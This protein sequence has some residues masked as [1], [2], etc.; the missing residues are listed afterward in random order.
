M[1]DGSPRPGHRSDKILQL[2]DTENS[3]PT[4]AI[5]LLRTFYSFGF[6]LFI[7]ES[8]RGPS[9]CGLITVSGRVYRCCKTKFENIFLIV[10]QLL[11]CS[12]E[13]LIGVHKQA[14]RLCFDRCLPAESQ[15]DRPPRP[16][17]CVCVCFL[18]CRGLVR[19]NPKETNY[20]SQLVVIETAVVH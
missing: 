10:G 9:A 18:C 20:F 19:I 12:G 16:L 11:L 13:E 8:F 5:F 2:D 14:D 4:S 1:A 15:H 3:M 7:R 6:L 17:L